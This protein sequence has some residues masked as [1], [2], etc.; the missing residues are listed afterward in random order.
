MAWTRCP[1]GLRLSPGAQGSGQGLRFCNCPLH[2]APCRAWPHAAEEQKG[3][4]SYEQRTTLGWRVLPVKAPLPVLPASRPALRKGLQS[5]CLASLGQGPTGA[6]RET[7]LALQLSSAMPSSCRPPPPPPAHQTQ[8][9]T[10]MMR[11]KRWV[12]QVDNATL[13]W[14]EPGGRHRR[15]VVREELWPRQKCARHAGWQAGTCRQSTGGCQHL[16]HFPPVR[17]T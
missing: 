5:S 15:R 9:A 7:G 1:D 13:V 11:D 4:H 3:E 16:P 14:A 8:L 12:P 6:H 2:P 17:S 10:L